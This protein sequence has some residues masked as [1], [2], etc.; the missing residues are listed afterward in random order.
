[1]NAASPYFRQWNTRASARI[2]TSPRQ[3]GEVEPSGTVVRQ[4]ERDARGS[5]A[6]KKAPGVSAAARTSSTMTI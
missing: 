4:F 6:D 5:R 3:R 2:P 1:L